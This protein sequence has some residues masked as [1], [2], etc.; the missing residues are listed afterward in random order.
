MYTNENVDKSSCC[1]QVSAT[2]VPDCSPSKCM[3]RKGKMSEKV[4]NCQ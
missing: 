1:R 3:K 4:T 2:F